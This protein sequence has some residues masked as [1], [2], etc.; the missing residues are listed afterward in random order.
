MSNENP[1]YMTGYDDCAMGKPSRSH[2]LL[3]AAREKYEAGY[4]RRY[5]EEQQLTHKTEEQEAC[6]TL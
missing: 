1:L 6:N 2:L 3:G 4:S 5:E